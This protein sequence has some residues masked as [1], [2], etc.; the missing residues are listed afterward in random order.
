FI[1]PKTASA[2]NLENLWQ[3]LWQRPTQQAA[4]AFTNKNFSQAAE[5]TNDPDWRAASLY[6]EGK[7]KEAAT[8]LE[9]LAS[10][11]AHY[12]RGNA[13]AHAGELEKAIEAYDQALQSDTN[14]EDARFNRELVEKLLQQQ[15]EQKKDQKQEE[16]SQDDESKKE[17]SDDQQ[18]SEQSQE[19]SEPGEQKDSQPQEKQQ[20]S[21]TEKNQNNQEQT[22]ADNPS[23][24]QPESESEAK[25][26]KESQTEEPDDPAKKSIDAAEKEDAEEEKPEE[27]MTAGEESDE[28]PM[29]AKQQALEQWLRRVP[30]DPRGLLEKKFLYQYR[31]RENRSQGNKAW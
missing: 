3:S 2:Q 15:Q 23:Q 19:S 24:E 12:N 17:N 26:N 18:N 7:F 30:D 22:S 28:K 20:N 16:N 25:K 5:L 6:R 14:L 27:A 1:T 4:Q 31:S 10:A 8:T 9:S 13:L 11:Q 21:Q 29:D